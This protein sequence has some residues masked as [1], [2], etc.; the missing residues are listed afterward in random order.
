MI[1]KLDCPYA[2]HGERMRLFC[3]KAGENALCVCQYYKSCK[4]WW[5]NSP[6]AK[7][8]LIRK[9]GKKDAEKD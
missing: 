5:V 2:Y 8:C 7:D 4:G 6:S 1:I 3:K 9:E